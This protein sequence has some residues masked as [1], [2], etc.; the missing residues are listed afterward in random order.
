MSTKTQVQKMSK[1]QIPLGQRQQ[2]EATPKTSPCPSPAP[3]LPSQELIILMLIVTA[4]LH[5]KKNAFF[6]SS[7]HGAM[8]MNLTRNHEVVGSI[9]GLA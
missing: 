4:S 7:R 8:E 3:A 1:R 2:A 5:L 9:A 6:R